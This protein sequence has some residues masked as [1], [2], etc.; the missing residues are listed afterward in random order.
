MLLIKTQLCKSGQKDFIKVEEA[1][2][3]M[4]VLVVFPLLLQMKR[5]RK[6]VN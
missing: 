1:C 4:I 2:K 6:N 5:W 3:T